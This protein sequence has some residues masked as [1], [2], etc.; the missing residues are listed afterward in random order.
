MTAASCNLPESAFAHIDA[1]GCPLT[2]PFQ[3]GA[4]GDAVQPFESFADAL[5]ALALTRLSDRDGIALLIGPEGAG[6]STLVGKLLD[7]PEAAEGCLVVQGERALT[8]S[9]FLRL[10][11][12]GFGRAG[13]FE[14]PDADL[15]ALSAL[16]VERGRSGRGSLVI[17]EQAERLGRTLL[18]ELDA[19]SNW[20]RAGHRLCH[21]VLVARSDGDGA[22]GPAFE[23][24]KAAW[25]INQYLVHVGHI[26]PK[27][28]VHTIRTTTN[29]KGTRWPRS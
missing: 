28:V 18:Q 3:I 14:N 7:Q 19:F 23:G 20:T 26:G 5:A 9:A 27:M 8:F 12:S 24:L 6:K 29:G 16:L 22:L 10:V 13:E 4:A 17:V 25:R 1:S 15:K 11:A 2:G 21:V